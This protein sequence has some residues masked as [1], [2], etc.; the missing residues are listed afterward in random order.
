MDLCGCD[1]P[2]R[3]TVA[4]TVRVGLARGVRVDDAGDAV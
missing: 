1:L 3:L 4:G 2:P